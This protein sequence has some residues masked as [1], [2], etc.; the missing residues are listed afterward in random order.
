MAFDPISGTFSFSPTQS[1]AGQTFLVNFT[2][3]DPTKSA[4]S[5]NKS[6]AIHVGNSANQPPAGGFCLNCILPKGFSV[7]MWLLIIGGLI[8]VI[9][10]I[11][12]LNVRAHV[13]LAGVRR[14]SQ[15]LTTDYGYDNKAHAHSHSENP[16]IISHRNWIPTHHFED[17]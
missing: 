6:V 11:S 15:H 4:A 14:R 5:S 8:G 2:A 9:S 1:Q 13:E 7:S 12:L 16:R 10:S 17:N 3:T